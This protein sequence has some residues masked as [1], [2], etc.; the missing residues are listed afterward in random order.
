MLTQLSIKMKT[1]TT[2]RSPLGSGT[3]SPFLTVTGLAEK[4]ENKYNLLLTISESDIICSV[5]NE[6]HAT[7]FKHYEKP[8]SHLS[9]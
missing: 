4:S 8:P 6:D 3:C 5:I 2:K 1:L 9:H 7:Q